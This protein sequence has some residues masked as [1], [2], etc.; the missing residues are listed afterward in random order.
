MH[1]TGLFSTNL[2]WPPPGARVA[3]P[4]VWLRGWVVGHAGCEFVDVR[5]RNATGIFLGVLGLPRVDLAAHFAP[6]R[7][8][9][10]AEFVVAVPAPDGPCRVQLEAQDAHGN[11]LELHSVEFIVAADGAANPRTEGKFVPA[12]GGGSVERVPHLPMHGHLDDPEDGAPISDGVLPVFGWFVHE[13][14]KIVRVTATFDARVFTALASG[15]TDDALAAKV[16]QL[17]AAR[18]GRVRGHVPYFATY[19]TTACLRLYVE[20]DDGSVQLALAR[21]LAPT[22]ATPAPAVPSAPLAQ[23][24]LPALPSGR[25]RRLLLVLRTLRPDDAARRAL[26]VVRWFAA[27]GR[28]VA[29]AIS[30]EDGPLTASLEAANCPVQQVD[31]RAF[32]KARG[33][34]AD[35]ELATLDRGIWWRHLDAVA[36]FDETSEW[37][38]PLARQ[39]GLP[40]FRDP[41][42]ELLWHAPDERMAFDASAPLVAPIRGAA[43]H[44]AP[45]L[46]ALA[47]D[48]GADFEVA[49]TDV[50]EDEEEQLFRASLRDPASVRVADAPPSCSA[51]VCPAWRD[52]PTHTL[53]TAIAS[54]V[55][56]ITTPTAPLATT[57]RAGELVFIP[58]G[59]PLALRHAIDDL[60]A[61]P[62]AALRRAA[63]AQRLVWGQ[64]APA[65][66]L[67]RWCAA[68]EAAVA[69][70][71]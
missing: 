41:S 65:R 7:R 10:P 5:A 52:H 57:F 71:R 50:R 31:L 21:R 49:V 15:L 43:R 47:A 63:A 70:G 27:G 2:E 23:V 37:I 29:R 34:A 3:G 45:T 8:W 67:P 24:E 6:P 16:P 40:I 59:N 32:S 60:R 44:G 55:P 20:L 58:P 35:A 68:L 46:L 54:G 17:P 53:L 56:I 22:P 26:D 11:W 39:H 30:A 9:L 64:H 4:I 12:P 25:P 51:I 33:V 19:P 28:W 69:A 38:A 13:Q 1:T 18:H 42:E 66:Q 61:R 36:V 62:E 48:S 14:R